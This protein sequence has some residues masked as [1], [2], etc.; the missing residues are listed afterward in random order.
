MFSFFSKFEKKMEFFA[1]VN[2]IPLH[3]SDTKRG[4]KTIV[5]LHGYL[6]TLYIFQ[7]FT[8]LLTAKGYRVISMDLPGHGLSGTNPDINT[9][10]F[11]SNL[12][13]SMLKEV[14]KVEQCILAGHSL[15]GCIAMDFIKKYPQMV[16]QLIILNSTPF[17]EPE[18]KEMDRKRE[19]DLILSSKLHIMASMG[20]PKMYAEQN[21]RKC[22]E[23]IEETVEICDTH[24]PAGIVA[25]IKG[26][27]AREE[28]V[29]AL[30]EAK[31]PIKFICGDMDNFI[32]N[33]D[34]ATI[35]EAL[36]NVQCYTISGTGHN[37]FIEAPERVLEIITA[38]D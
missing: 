36:P 3:I 17:P 24:D 25:T 22:E 2:N 23:K 33:A 30:K 21:L 12:V 20:I 29:T 15:G 26:F 8:P 16:S 27:I 35:K 38:Q 9:I 37:S 1:T 13:R 31:M 7:E 34:A 28:S 10:P 11:I 4:D 32:S 5:L 18:G 6:E 14:C 19:M